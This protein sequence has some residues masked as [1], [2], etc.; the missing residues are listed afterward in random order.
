MGNTI[1]P[2]GGR[3]SILGFIAVALGVIAIAAPAV[4]AGTVVITVGL[5]MLAA[6]ITQLVE[7]IRGESWRHRMVP[8]ILGLIG[9][10]SGV[11]VLAHPLLGLGFLTLLLVVF[12]V[13]EGFWKMFASLK[14]RNYQGWI[15]MLLSGVLSLLLGVLIWNQWP[16][17]GVWAIGILVGVELLSTGISLVILGSAVREVSKKTV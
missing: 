14:F 8:V 15:W 12:F 6:G 16:L 17:S 1:T 13:L 7:G 9:S 11:L 10:V 4:A 3:L 2:S 5:T